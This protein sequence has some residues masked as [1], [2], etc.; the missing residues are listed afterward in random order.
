MATPFRL[1]DKEIQ[2]NFALRF[3][4]FSGMTFNKLFKRHVW[5]FNK[6]PDV[7]DLMYDWYFVNSFKGISRE[8]MPAKAQALIELFAAAVRK[9]EIEERKRQIRNE[10]AGLITIEQAKERFWFLEIGYAYK[11]IRVRAKQVINW[12]TRE[13]ALDMNHCTVFLSSSDTSIEIS[14]EGVYDPKQFITAYKNLVEKNLKWAQER[15][16]FLGQMQ[17]MGKQLA[18]EIF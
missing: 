16:A 4:G 5:F 17:E 9:G 2:R 7:N 6:F 12:E 18:E 15:L 13:C 11:K 3:P 10:A 1:L 14:K 8:D